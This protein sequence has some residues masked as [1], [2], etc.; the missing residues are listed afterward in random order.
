MSVEEENPLTMQDSFSVRH[1]TRNFDESKWSEEKQA[2]VEEIVR[3]VNA[4]PKIFGGEVEV[5][6][7]PRGFGFLNRFP[8]FPHVTCAALFKLHEPRYSYRV[9][10]VTHAT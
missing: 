2:K 1:S 9:S 8:S 5:V 6:L 4:L 10:N 3:E 7:A